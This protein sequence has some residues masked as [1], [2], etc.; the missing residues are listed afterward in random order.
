MPN[1]IANMQTLYRVADILR[2]RGIHLIIIIFPQSPEYA[3]TDAF[4]RHGPSH[5]TA[6]QVIQDVRELESY[7]TNVHLYDAYNSGRTKVSDSDST[8]TEFFT[9]YFFSENKDLSLG[10]S[11]FEIIDYALLFTQTPSHQKIALSSK[12]SIDTKLIPMNNPRSPDS[13]LS[14][15]HGLLTTLK[16]MLK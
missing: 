14:D 4:G 7:Y 9:H 1:Y 15:H 8:H 6:Q 10:Q 2:Q 12:Y 13:A 16:R 5:E 11:S 3:N